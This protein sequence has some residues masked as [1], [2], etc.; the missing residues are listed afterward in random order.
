MSSAEGPRTQRESRAVWS[1]SEAIT[2][3]N[4]I[5]FDPEKEYFVFS[6][7]PKRNPIT[8]T[9]LRIL[10]SFE[11]E[12]GITED[13]GIL[14]IETGKKNYVGGESDKNNKRRDTSRLSLHTHPNHEGEAT[15]HTPSFSDIYITDFASKNTPLVLATSEG[16]IFYGKPTYDPINK[17]A[18]TGEPRDLMLM[19]SKHYG[20]DIFCANLDGLKNFDS[21]SKPEMAAFQRRFAIETKAITAEIPWS[22]TKRI[23]EAMKIVNLGR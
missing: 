2:Y 10:T 21:M 8:P 14:Y 23:A 6:L 7:D 18:W 4:K 13:R 19:Y 1:V 11:F 12:F 17:K 22:D 3:L 15:V 20:Y 16:I 9:E 5:R